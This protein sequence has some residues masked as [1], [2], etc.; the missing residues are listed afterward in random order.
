MPT[1]PKRRLAVITCMDARI[2]PA[3]ILGFG[4]GDAHVIRNGGGDAREA[5]RSLLLSQHLLETR[6]VALIR[7]T[8]CGLSGSSNE[9][10]RRKVAEGSGGDA[11]DIDFLPF[12][13]LE[14]AVREDMRFLESSPLIAPGSTIRGFVYE[15]ET[16]RLREVAP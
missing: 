6:Q 4:E 9:E 11:S 15:V 14:E 7:H 13:D 2:D 3:R 16:D 12:A 1:P 8:D 5:L 10:I